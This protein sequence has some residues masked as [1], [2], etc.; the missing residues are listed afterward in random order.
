MEEKEENEGKKGGEVGEGAEGCGA[1]KCKGK[2]IR[3][4]Y[5]EILVKHI[6]QQ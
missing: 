3:R 4:I 2:A 1:L 5:I 6:W